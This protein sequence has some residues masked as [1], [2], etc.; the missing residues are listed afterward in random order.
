MQ[1]RQREGVGLGGRRR[2]PQELC[3][4]DLYQGVHR[5]C[6]SNNATLYAIFFSGVQGRKRGPEFAN[7]SVD[8]ND[9]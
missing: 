3:C 2:V 6:L 5:T 8:V 7:E 4:K 9:G 1:G